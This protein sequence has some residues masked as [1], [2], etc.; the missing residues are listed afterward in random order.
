MTPRDENL[1]L[2]I[3]DDAGFASNEIHEAAWKSAVL[4]DF[5][6]MVG[7][8]PPTLEDA[9]WFYN[10]TAEEAAR[11]AEIVALEMRRAQEDEA[12][13]WRVPA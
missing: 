6:G 7:S 4:E 13:Q 3:K 11:E 2:I 12:D 5:F 10:R 8:G 1:A 9:E